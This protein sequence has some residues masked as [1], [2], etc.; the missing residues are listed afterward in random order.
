M[1]LH[2]WPYLL[3]LCTTMFTLLYKHDNTE[4][5]F[6]RGEDHTASSHVGMLTDKP[7][8]VVE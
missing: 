3:S 7:E 6:F 4:V 5:A 2:M 8:H 1:L